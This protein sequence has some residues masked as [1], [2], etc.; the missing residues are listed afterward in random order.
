MRIALVLMALTACGR[1]DFDALGTAG[2]GPDAPGTTACGDAR[3]L[4]C[5]PLEGNALDSSGHG[6]DAA[7]SGVTYVAGVT[8]LA[9]QT[10][11][12]S[13]IDLI[14]PSLA[15]AAITI[16]A[17]VRPDPVGTLTHV[18]DH[19]SHWAMRLLDDGTLQCVR[20]ENQVNGP[21]VTF[22]A[23][24]HVVCTLDGTTIRAYVGASTPVEG[25]MSA[26]DPGSGPAAI[27]GDAP[28]T[29]PPSPLSATVDTVKI[30][31]VAL[32]RAEVCADLG[33]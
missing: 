20:N 29:N 12:A 8:G 14:A 11:P 16:E 15:S 18:F 13:R 30:Y 4:A 22:Q 31:G 28:P 5:Y 6:N 25:P 23:W 27:A 17:W 7:A 10:T 21:A 26:I 3:L 19:D 33:C 9:V 2:G 1:V 24:N 32:S